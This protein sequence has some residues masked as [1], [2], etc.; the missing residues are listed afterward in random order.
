[1]CKAT[2]SQ[3][4]RVAPPPPFPMRMLTEPSWVGSTVETINIRVS[5][6]VSHE[7]EHKYENT[8]TSTTNASTTINTTHGTWTKDGMATPTE[9]LTLQCCMVVSID[10]CTAVA[11]F[12]S[13]FRGH[14]R[15]QVAYPRVLVEP[16]PVP[17]K[18]RTPGHRYGF[19]GVW[20]RVALENPR[21][22]CAN[23]YMV[24]INSDWH[25]LL[26]DQMQSRVDHSQPC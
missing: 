25:S 21:V 12:L 11:R 10:T 15:A 5:T 16:V 19:S 17:V 23:P 13:Q 14:T 3:T 4:W 22:T 7:H 18:T 9:W 24:L 2:N 20:V 26:A 6:G 8:H 1:M